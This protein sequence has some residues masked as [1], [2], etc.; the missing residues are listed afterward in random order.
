MLNANGMGISADGNYVFLTNDQATPNR[1]NAVNVSNPASMSVVGTYTN[2]N[3][4]ESYDGLTLG[5]YH[6][7]SNV[8]GTCQ[9]QVTNIA[10][11]SSPSLVATDGNCVTEANGPGAFVVKGR[12]VYSADYT[13]STI[14][15]WDLG[16]DPLG[17]GTLGTCSVMGQIEYQAA[18]KALVYCNGTNWKIIAK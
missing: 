18:N 16:C 8:F 7:A 12:Y 3:I 2:A 9:L 14:S 15:T 10:T 11:P 13:G 5:N 4:I 6:L 1:F 17:S